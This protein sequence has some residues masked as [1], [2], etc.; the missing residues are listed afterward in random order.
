M[1]SEDLLPSHVKKET[2]DGLVSTLANS[3]PKMLT[4]IALARKRRAVTVS[5]LHSDVN[6]AQGPEPAWKVSRNAIAKFCFGTLRE[7]QLVVDTK[8]S[9]HMVHISKL[10][11]LGAS[12]AGTL[13]DWEEAHED[14]TLQFLLGGGSTTRERLTLYPQALGRLAGKSVADF[15]KHFPFDN[16]DIITRRLETLRN[17]GIITSVD[18]PL[19]HYKLQS[20]PP[21]STSLF[22]SHQLQAPLRSLFNKLDTFTQNP[23]YRDEMYKQATSLFLK[24]NAAKTNGLMAKALFYSSHGPGYQRTLVEWG[25]MVRSCVPQKGVDFKSLVTIVRQKSG[26]PISDAQLHQRLQELKNLGIV[27]I[28][29]TPTGAKNKSTTNWIQ[30]Q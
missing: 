3:T 18:K 29:K 2:V 1:G 12:L 11:R 4:L 22:V 10:G 28:T 13:L 20:H 25:E 17:A 7:S 24:K 21:H 19:L 26:Q 16:P 8:T 6:A 30:L 15:A 9:P 23:I 14:V 27:D 5:T